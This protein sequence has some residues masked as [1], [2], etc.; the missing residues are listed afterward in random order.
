MTFQ[1]SAVT[2]YSCVTGSSRDTNLAS[3]SAPCSC[4]SS[5]AVVVSADTLM[6]LAVSPPG[7][8]NDD[9]KTPGLESKHSGVAS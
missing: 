8:Q 7:L 6:Q 5:M 2:W 9:W 1:K 4:P 3:H